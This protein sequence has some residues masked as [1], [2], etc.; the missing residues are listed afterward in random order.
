MSLTTSALNTEK[1]LFTN[2]TN[3]QSLFTFRFFTKHSR[4]IKE[5]CTGC[6]NSADI[7]L[8]LTCYTVLWSFLLGFFTLLLK[9]AIDTDETHTLLW[10]FFWF[11]LMFSILVFGATKVG[12]FEIEREKK[13]KKKAAEELQTVVNAKV[14]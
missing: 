11:G 12:T 7:I 14:M 6:G 8:V 13:E 2:T 1:Q 4:P 9:G 10:T 5:W 3:N